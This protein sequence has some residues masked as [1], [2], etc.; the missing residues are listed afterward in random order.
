[1]SCEAASKAGWRLSKYRSRS[2]PQVLVYKPSTSERRENS[3]RSLHGK[4]G[5]NGSS[6]L[7]GSAKSPARRGFCVQ[8]DLL[9]LDRAVG[10]E[11]FM[12]LWRSQALSI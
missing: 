9:E 4:E 2:R 7:E 1:M 11:L 8:V 10:M 6:P 3:L 5:V 12:K